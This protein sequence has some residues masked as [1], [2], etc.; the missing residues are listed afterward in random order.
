MGCLR[1]LLNGF[2]MPSQAHSKAFK[3]LLKAV[4]RQLE[5]FTKVFPRHSQGL[6]KSF[7]HLLKTFK[8]ISRHFPGL[9]P[10]PLLDALELP[11][12]FFESA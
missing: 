4:Q 3:N 7:K 8:N 5:D 12:L 6:Y 10:G 9:P 1:S 11:Q 2:S